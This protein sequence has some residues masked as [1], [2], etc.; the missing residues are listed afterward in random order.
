MSG[1]LKL[2]S[3]KCWELADALRGSNDFNNCASR[4]YYSVF[5][6]VVYFAMTKKGYDP[7]EAQRRKLN[8]HNIMNHIVD[9]EISQ[10]ADAYGEM[11][12]LRNKADYDPEDVA[13]VDISH[14]F[15]VEMQGIRSFFL[16]EAER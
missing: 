13:A 12:Q 3:N 1:S 11:R 16:T 5:Q 10:Y 9:E 2:K 4:M 7:E 6:A 15:L 8:A 14:H